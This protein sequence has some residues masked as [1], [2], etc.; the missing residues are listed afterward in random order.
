M[1]TCL[2][3]RAVHIEVLEEITSS[4]FINALRRFCAVR[5]E[6]KLIRSDCRNNFVGSVKDL[7]ATV[8]STEDRPIK[9]YL[10]E[11][12]INWIFNPPHF[13]HMGGVWERMTGVARRVLDSRLLD[14]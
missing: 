9:E 11:N 10:S 5:G 14:V 2:V 12:R 13:S 4:C 8:I 6:V 7:N 3:I 1:I